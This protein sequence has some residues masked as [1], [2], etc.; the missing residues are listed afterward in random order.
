MITATYD[1]VTIVEAD[2]TTLRKVTGT[3]VTPQSDT[4]WVEYYDGAKL[5]HRSVH[6]KLKHHANESFGPLSV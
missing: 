2:E 6:V 3:T 1:G 5:V 4:D